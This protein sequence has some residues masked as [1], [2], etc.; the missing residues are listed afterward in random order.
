MKKSVISDIFYGVKGSQE[1]MR[2]PQEHKERLR[3]VHEGYEQLKKQLSAADF[4]LHEQFVQ[5][6][7]A[8]FCEEIEFY[9]VEGFKLGLR[10]GMECAEE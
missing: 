7:E 6:M 2:M 9:F 8:S 5:A 4:S 10:I 3:K 1:T